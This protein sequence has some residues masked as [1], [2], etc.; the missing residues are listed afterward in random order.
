MVAS[1]RLL[2]AIILLGSGV[3]LAQQVPTDAKSLLDFHFASERASLTHD[4]Y[5][6]LISGAAFQLS[7]TLERK[8]LLD[9]DDYRFLL[10]ASCWDPASRN[11]ASQN[12]SDWLE[13]NSKLSGSSAFQQVEEISAFL[14]K[15]LSRSAEIDDRVD[16]LK[17][18][19]YSISAMFC[20]LLYKTIRHYV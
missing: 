7:E 6:Y 5:V 12:A 14:D 1:L 10:Q 15:E 3:I 4:A 8:E 19:L 2:A 20:L 11:S 9:A 16:M 17:Y 18:I 13:N